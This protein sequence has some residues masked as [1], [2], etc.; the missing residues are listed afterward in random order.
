MAASSLSQKADQSAEIEAEP[1][2]V[3]YTLEPSIRPLSACPA[4]FYHDLLNQFSPSQP[5]TNKDLPIN[6]RLFPSIFSPVVGFFFFP[7]QIYREPFAIR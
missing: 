2:T 6:R 1:P 4:S 7:S 5:F 3:Q